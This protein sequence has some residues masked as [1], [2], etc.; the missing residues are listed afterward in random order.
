M[1]G[2]NSSGT[3]PGF[4]SWLGSRID[5]QSQ[6]V[7]GVLIVLIVATSLASPV[8]LTP[9]NLVNVLRQ[10]SILG[11][12]AS[13]MTVVM[14]SGGIDLSVGAVLSFVGCVAAKALVHGYGI[15][16]ALLIG[17][18]GGAAMGF[19]NGIIIANTRAHPFIITLGTMT[20]IQG[21]AL[22]VTGSYPTM[23]EGAAFEQFLWL[24][25]GSVLWIPV[26]IIVFF[27]VMALCSTLLRRTRFGRHCYAVGGS[28]ATA[29]LSGIDIKRH[30]VAIYTFVGA[31][32]GLASLVLTARLA[33]ALPTMGSGY[34]LQCIAA[35][36]IGGVAL[37]GGR[38]NMW[39]AFTGVLLLGVISNSL[40]L[41][42]VNAFYQYIVLGSIIVFAV[43]LQEY[44]RST[45]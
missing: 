30:K 26:P 42:N 43:V 41:L 32:T 1:E 34:E 2:R 18:G 21:V 22:V 5:W 7:L 3:R 12:V 31:L 4:L 39:A 40:S 10:I 24:G 35:I 23:A 15:P 36:V 11:M 13:G 33:S 8:F 20:L 29:Y 38:G 28:E 37:M 9:I 45:R 17:I 14:I 16:V 19:F 25:T 27:L 6:G 44:R